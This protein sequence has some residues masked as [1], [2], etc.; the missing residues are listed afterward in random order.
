MSKV[1]EVT[2][3]IFNSKWFW[4]NNKEHARIIAGQICQLFDAECQKRVDIAR[5]E[6]EHSIIERL[7]R[8]TKTEYKPSELNKLTLIIERVIKPSKRR[9][10]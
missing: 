10:V 3:I 2:D 6:G 5:S 4:S 8:E 9:K 7:I 1:E